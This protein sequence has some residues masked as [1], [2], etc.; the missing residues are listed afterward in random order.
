VV[1][2]AGAGR[3]WRPRPGPRLYL[4]RWQT[5]GT[6]AVYGNG[7]LLWQSRGDGRVFNRPVWIDLGG[8]APPGHRWRCTCAWPASATRAAR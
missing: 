1:S 5:L 3:R 7:R 4:P 6:L 8:V 2:P